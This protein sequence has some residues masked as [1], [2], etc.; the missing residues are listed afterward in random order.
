M[1]S[2]DASVVGLKRETKVTIVEKCIRT[3]RHIDTT[4]RYKP[5]GTDRSTYNNGLASGIGAKNKGAII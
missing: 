3:G 5:A 2:Y 1:Y 4:I